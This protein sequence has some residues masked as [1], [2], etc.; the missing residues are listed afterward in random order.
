VRT[1]PAS[2]TARRSVRCPVP[3]AQPNR[4][5]P[6]SG[7]LPMSPMSDSERVGDDRDRGSPEEVTPNRPLPI[8]TGGQMREA[9]DASRH[10]ANSWPTRRSTARARDGAKARPAGEGAPLEYRSPGSGHS[11]YQTALY[12]RKC[13]TSF[14]RMKRPSRAHRSAHGYAAGRPIRKGVLARLDVRRV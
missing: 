11:P 13:H 9:G 1:A 8:C 10:E 4:A 3:T 12:A 2:P 7:T 14:S 6:A 5:V